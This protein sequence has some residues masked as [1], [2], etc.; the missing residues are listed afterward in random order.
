MRQFSRATAGR[1]L[2]SRSFVAVFLFLVF[3]L[4]IG[5]LA[6]AA[7]PS[8]SMV[9]WLL[10]GTLGAF[11]VGYLTR[12]AVGGFADFDAA[13]LVGILVMAPLL[14][15][16]FGRSPTPRRVGARVRG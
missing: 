16:V 11:I 9:A 8:S 13:G 6:R 3:A 7:M 12:L 10:S 15:L 2:A 5:F 4:P 14:L 1:R